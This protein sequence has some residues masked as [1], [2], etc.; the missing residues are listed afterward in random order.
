VLEAMDANAANALLEG[1][2]F[3][4]GRRL[5]DEGAVCRGGDRVELYAAR[6]VHAEV[7][8]LDQRA[9][10]VAVEKP[11]ELPTEP[12][13]H[14]S[15]CVLARAAAALG[16]DPTSL[17]AVSRLD[18]GVSGVLL[19]A[20]ERTALKNAVELRR[21][22]AFRRGYCAL[23]AGD[24]HV[25]G[26]SWTDKVGQRQDAETQFRV[27]AR[28]RRARAP[29]HVTA[30]ALVPVTGRTHQLRLHARS[31][32][33][34]LLGDR[35]Y[36]APSQWTAT[37]G[38]VTSIRR[39]WLHCARVRLDLERGAPWRLSSRAESLSDAWC[40]LGGVARDIEGLVSGELFEESWSSA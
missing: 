16:V 28:L 19:L 40:A 39:I 21:S 1:R 8:I 23:T 32:G 38:A 2:V 5:R 7:R 17:H 12:D 13:R 15:D 22:G 29:E 26:G 10:F 35:R 14:G 24:P 36:G 20:R 4:N 34:P 33:L 37:D 30:L 27:V 25:L 9:G 6:R 18:V 11:H 3:V 31:A